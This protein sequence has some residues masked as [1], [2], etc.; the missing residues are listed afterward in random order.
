MRV[1]PASPEG[2]PPMLD[3]RALLTSLAATGT[4]G[5][6]AACSPSATSGGGSGG[7][8]GEKSLTFRLWDEA[9]KPAYEESFAA[10]TEQSGWSV[11]IDLVPWA[12]YWTKLPLDVASGDMADVY[13]M[14]SAN[15]VQ[16]QQSGDLLAVDEVVPEGADQW[17]Q[18]VVDLYT[19]DGSLW[20]VPQL[21]DSIA[22]FYNVDLV[23]KAG[24][25][26]SALSF[27]PTAASDPL[28]EA[29]RA[30]TLDGAGRTPG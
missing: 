6:L 13:W 15:F 2:S 5:A 4:L 25:D 21:W 19:R 24:V 12:D 11:S 18:S 29:A 28:R 14:N 20:G 9:A 17:E 27:D 10:F 23:E 8:T 16:L 30:L 1:L 7:G 3:R 26:V 22:L